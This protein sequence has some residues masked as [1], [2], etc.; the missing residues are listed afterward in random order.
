M[1]LSFFFA[2]RYLF[3]RKSHSVINLV[4]G[5]SS[6]TVAIP[7]MAMVVL[8][9]VFNGFDSLIR[10]M[11]QHFDPPIEIS[12]SKG[13]VFDLSSLDTAAV[14]S[15]DGV[16]ELSFVLEETALFQYRDRQQIGI[17]KGVDSLFPAVVPI[18]EMVV[19]GEYALK[20]GD[21]D[22]TI[23]GQGVAYALSINPMIAEP[24]HVYMPRRGR[25]VSFLPVDMYRRKA[26]F[27]SGIFA[28]DGDTDGKYVL[29]PLGFAQELLDYDS[30]T[31]SAAAVGLAEGSDPNRI[32]EQIA[33]IVGDDFRVKTRLQQ[34]AELYRL[35]QYEKWGIYFIILLVLV[36]ASFSIIGSLIMIIVDK[37]KDTET[38]VMLGADV[39]LIRRIFIREGLL[40][41]GAGT[42]AGLLLGVLVCL[43]QQHFGLVKMAG[44]SFLVDAYPVEL[45]LTD[46]IGV[47]ASVCAVNFLIA[48]LT[49]AGMIRR[50]ALYKENETG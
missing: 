8:L 1:R 40:I 47:V 11:Y 5:I 20:F 3:S 50:R 19:R 17:V 16:T 46:L 48:H 23:L 7:V 18:E 9:S 38:L 10:S 25:T 31:V 6:F 22:Q 24:L 29:V 37:K 41:S 2:R 39:P 45:R 32:R 4:S 14:R 49:V 42:V 27:P 33:R 30:R 36:I 13:K 35:M 26:I 12:P 44:T 21:I 34:K 43:L 28:L 15:L